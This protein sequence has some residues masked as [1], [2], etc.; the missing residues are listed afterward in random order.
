MIFFI[1]GT[2]TLI[3]SN[4][5]IIPRVG[6]EIILMGEDYEVKRVIYNLD[7]DNVSVYMMTM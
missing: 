4:R 6:E 3:G 1:K 2:E 5:K 7:D